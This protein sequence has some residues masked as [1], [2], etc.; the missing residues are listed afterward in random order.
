MKEKVSFTIIAY[1]EEKNIANCINSILAQEGLKNY[2]IVVVNDGSKDNTSKIVRSLSNLNKNINFIDLKK[3]KGRGFA[4]YTAVKN[5]KGDYVAFVDADIILPKHWLKSCLKYL[6]DYDAVGGTA[7][8][9]GDVS[10]VYEKFE[11]K[12]RI[13]PQTTETTG[14][15]SFYK[16]KVFNNFD[17]NRNLKFGEDSDLNL[18]LKKNGFK[19]KGIND[20]IVEHRENKSLINS[21]KFA[22]QNGKGAS[23]QLYKYKKIRLPD[24]AFFGFI[25]IIIASSLSS[26]FLS[27]YVLFLIVLYPLLTSFLHIRSKF[28]FTINKSLSYLL[29]IMVNY[30][31]MLAYYIGRILGGLR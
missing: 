30:P 18:R 10:Y 16:K 11:L 14:S 24:L 25:F 20:L 12:P 23:R 29:A 6:K 28:Y 15:N 8:P 22:Y 17:F 31:M 26:L 7:V 4:R 5:A 2:E 3:N 21:I 9:D 19:L 27:K 13:I 1:N